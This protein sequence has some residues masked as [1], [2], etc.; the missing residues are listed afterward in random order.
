MGQR[1]GSFWPTWAPGVTTTDD[2]AWWMRQR[3]SD[4]GLDTWFQPDVDVQR[5]GVGDHGHAAGPP[6]RLWDRQDGVP[7]R[8]DIPLLPQTWFAIELQ[9]T[10]VPEWDG[11]PLRS[12]QEEDAELTTDGTM[13]WILGRQTA[14]HLVR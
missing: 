7:A 11:Q 2:A 4:L 13:R 6:I 5:H 9:T 10:P 12:M 14:F 8:G 1:V 3:L